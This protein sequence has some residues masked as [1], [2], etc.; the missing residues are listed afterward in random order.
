V[1]LGLPL[2]ERRIFTLIY[3]ASFEDKPV[4]VLYQVKHRAAKD[5]PQD[6]V[7]LE[8]DFNKARIE[9]YP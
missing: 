5:S 9:E 4:E 1:K 6:R 2:D 7:R 3:W 8:F